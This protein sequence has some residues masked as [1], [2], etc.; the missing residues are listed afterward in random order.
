MEAVLVLLVPVVLLWM[1]LS[2]TRGRPLSPD[3]VL[4]SLSRSS[5]RTLKWLW[6]D[7]TKQGGAGRL[8]RPPFR[9]RK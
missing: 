8:G 9:Y 5:W 6:R 2:L 3:G 7:R 4:R 1:G